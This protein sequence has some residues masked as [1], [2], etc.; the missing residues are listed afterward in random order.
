MPGKRVV[1]RSWYGPCVPPSSCK[2]PMHMRHSS[3]VVAS[4]INAGYDEPERDAAPLVDARTLFYVCTWYNV[5][6]F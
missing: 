1:R 2:I 6:R 5:N 4:V 3:K